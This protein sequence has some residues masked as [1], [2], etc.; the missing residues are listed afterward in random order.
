MGIRPAIVPVA[1]Y[2]GAAINNADT[3]VTTLAPWVYLG[4]VVILLGVSRIVQMRNGK[5]WGWPFAVVVGF[6]IAM[7][8][9]FVAIGLVNVLAPNQV[10]PG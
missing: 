4:T 9:W 8:A 1:V 5:A 6:G 7:I 2:M 10:V 3:I